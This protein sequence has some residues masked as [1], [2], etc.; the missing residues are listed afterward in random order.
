MREGKGEESTKKARERKTREENECLKKRGV[1]ERGEKARKKD[2][3][4]M[5]RK[6]GKGILRYV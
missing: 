2:K 1:K 4:G 5:H 6:I 3:E